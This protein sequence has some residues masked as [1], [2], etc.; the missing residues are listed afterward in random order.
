MIYLPWPGIKPRTLSRGY[1]INFWE[2][3]WKYFW[4][5][6]SECYWTEIIWM[7]HGEF[8]FTI[9]SK[10]LNNKYIKIIFNGSYFNE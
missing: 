8:N 5:V 7:T 2:L 1:T 10:L 6:I 4:E 9:P 3:S